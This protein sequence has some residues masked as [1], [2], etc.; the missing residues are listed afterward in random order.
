MVDLHSQRRVATYAF[1]RHRG[2]SSIS[3]AVIPG[4]LGAFA[5][6]SVPSRALGIDY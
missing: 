1:V 3:V 6:V 4:V 5:A 2:Q